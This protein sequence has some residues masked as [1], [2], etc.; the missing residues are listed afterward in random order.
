MNWKIK[1]DH[2]YADLYR[3][4]GQSYIEEAGFFSDTAKTDVELKDSV[5]ILC[6]PLAN[7]SKAL[8]NNIKNPVVLLT[9]GAFCPI[10]NGHVEMMVNAKSEIEKMGY[11]VISGYVSP[12]HDEYIYDKNKEKAIPIHQRIKLI[13]EMIKEHDWL[14]VDPWE[15][16]F[17]KVAV[18]FTDVVRRLELYIEH[19]VGIHVPVVFVCGSDNARFAKTFKNQGMCVVVNRPPYDEKY[20]KYRDEIKNENIF[21]ANGTNDASSTKIRNLDVVKAS[22][23]KKNL[24]IRAEGKDEREAAIIELLEKRFNSITISNVDDQSKIFEQIKKSEGYS[25]IS[26]DSLMPA[27]HNL[28][29]SRQYDL[30]GDK[31]IRYTKRPN[32]NDLEIQAKYIPKGKYVLFDDDIH[33]GGTIKFAKQELLKHEINIEYAISFKKTANETD[34]IIDVRDFLIDDSNSGLVV[35]LPIGDSRA[36]YIYPYVCPYLRASIEDPTKFSI[37][38]WKINEEYFKT[39]SWK[40]IDYPHLIDLFVTAGFKSNDTMHYICMKH[41]EYLEE[42]FS[43]N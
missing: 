5:N 22:T 13:S 41:R 29:I 35:K 8:A 20:T 12:G 25:L 38:I 4:F 3:E 27:K 30:F 10:H 36:P 42:V 17:C 9:C 19:H 32:S 2:F 6:T 15:G 14:N 39:K 16:L 1:R 23:T 34:E 11:N 37:E 28:K 43:I 24:Y 18:N 33:T 21:W 40:L 26:L 31:F 7:I